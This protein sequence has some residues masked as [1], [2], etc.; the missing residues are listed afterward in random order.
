MTKTIHGFVEGKF[1]AVVRVALIKLKFDNIV[2]PFKNVFILEGI[3]K[4]EPN[5]IC[6]KN[7]R[8]YFYS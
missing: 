1:S 7:N 2:K 3:T 8:L 4:I 6:S 5:I